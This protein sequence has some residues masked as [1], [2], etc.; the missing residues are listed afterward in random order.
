[1]FEET[2]ITL[3][4]GQYL[5]VLKIKTGPHTD[6]KWFVWGVILVAFTTEEVVGPLIQQSGYEPPE[7]ETSQVFPVDRLP[8]DS[9]LAFD[10]GEILREFLGVMK[11]YV[12]QARQILSN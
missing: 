7:I 2:G 8:P 3:T 5:D 6:P 1:M 11:G 9:H 10:H 12:D 4:A